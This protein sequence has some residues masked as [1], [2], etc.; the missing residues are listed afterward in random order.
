MFR[1]MF[2]A[3]ISYIKKTETSQIMMHFKLLEKQEQTEPKI[4]RW[5]EKIKVRDEINEIE[6][7]QTI[8]RI[9]ETK[10]WFL[11]KINKIDKPLANMTKW[12]RE[13]TQI[14]QIGDEK[15]NIITNTN[16]I[17]SIFRGYF[18]NL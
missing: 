12:R 5:R 17:Q 11:A 8:Q 10:D 2:I 18:K 7:K 14:N 4:S 16:K 6:T 9:N 3:I 15:G 1:G 13:K